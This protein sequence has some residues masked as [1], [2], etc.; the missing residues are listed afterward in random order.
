MLTSI[1]RKSN[2]WCFRR[3]SCLSLKANRGLASYVAEQVTFP[4]HPPLPLALPSVGKKKIQLL[5]RSNIPEI[6]ATR[7]PHLPAT[8]YLA[9]A[10]VFPMRANNYVVEELIDWSRVPDDPI[11]KLVFPQPDMLEPD[12]LHAVRSAI[13]RGASKSELRDLAA[14]FTAVGS[15]QQFQSK[16]VTQLVDYLKAN[17]D[18][19][20]ILFTGGDPMVMHTQQFARYVDA[21]LSSPGTENLATIRIGSKSLSYWP[22]RYLTDPDA[23]EMLKLFEKIVKSG[24][25]LSIMAHFSHP[26]ELQGVAVQEAMRRIRATGANIRCQAPLIRQVND[27]PHIWADMWR[28]QTRLGAIPYY[29]FVERDTGAKHYFEVP[30]ARAFDIYREAIS[31]VAGTARTVQGPSMSASPGKIQVVGITTIN[32]PSGPEKVF[33]LRFLQARNPAWMKET[34]FAKFDEK[35]SWLND[36]KPAF[37]EKEFFYEKEYRELVKREGASGQLF[38][39]SDSM[40]YRNRIRPF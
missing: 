10:S 9:A 27:Q 32:T 38:P 34:F 37:G 15:D 19:T 12:Q 23:G 17:R 4:D 28:T 22:Y 33:I 39:A 24:R 6:F 14:Q 7:A 2:A 36:L 3:A 11:F 30:L 18:V 31:S 35:A 20:D 26:V 40:K 8:D 25:H 1:L 21:L 16:D 5:T 13:E 29:M